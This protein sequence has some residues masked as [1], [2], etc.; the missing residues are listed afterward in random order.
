M[1]SI[2]AIFKS[3]FSFVFLSKLKDIVRINFDL[4]RKTKESKDF[5]IASTE[6]TKSSEKGIFALGILF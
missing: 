1:I 4:L 3:Q 2:D 5:K 6:I